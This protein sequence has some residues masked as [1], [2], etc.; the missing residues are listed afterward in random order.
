[1]LVSSFPLCFLACAASFATL[2]FVHGPLVD[3]E[4][5]QPPPGVNFLSYRSCQSLQGGAVQ[6]V[7]SDRLLLAGGDGGRRRVDRQQP[8]DLDL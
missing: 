1:M 6:V 2:T 5:D 3:L 7:D 8:H 4:G